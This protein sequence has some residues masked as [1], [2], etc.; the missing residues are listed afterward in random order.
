[1]FDIELE[2][3][4]HAL[5]GSLAIYFFR[6]KY[7]VDALPWFKRDFADKLPEGFAGTKTA[8]AAEQIKIRMHCVVYL[9][10]GWLQMCI[11]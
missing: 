10:D 9:P 6:H 3:A 1:M 5:N 8:W 7:R 2:D 4:G 11:G